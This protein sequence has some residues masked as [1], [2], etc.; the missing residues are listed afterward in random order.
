MMRRVFVSTICTVLFTALTWAGSIDRRPGDVNPFLEADN[1]MTFGEDVERDKQA[2]AVAERSL[3]SETGNYQ[4][5]WR[6]SRAA[7]YVG[8][9][10][11]KTEKLRFYE[12]GI[13]VGQQAIALQP[14]SV[15]GHF[16]LA[17]NYGGYSEM[18]GAFKALRMVKS[19]RAEM[20]TVLKLNDRYQDGSAYL[21]L[22]EIDRQLPWLLGGDTKRAITRLEQGLRVAPTNLELKLGLARAYQDEGRKE[23]ARRQLQEILERQVN[24]AKAKSERDV[25]EKA[26]QLIK[27]L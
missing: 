4:W 26:R 15:E 24:P 27:K 5:Q 19:I 14:S 6:V 8:D 10:A 1:L 20:E 21:A 9:S 25:Q 17:A 22:G 13:A 3:G 12:R 23:D 11:P 7:F 2:L 16:W 18:K